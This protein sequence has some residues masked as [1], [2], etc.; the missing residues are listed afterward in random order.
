MATGNKREISEILR[1]HKLSNGSPNYPTLFAIPTAHRITSLAK[2]NF[3]ETSV[4]IAAGITLATESMNLKTPMN[5]AQIV[6]LAEEIIDTASEDNLALEDVML[7][8]QGLVRGRYG[9]LYE[10]MDIPKFME[11][12]E[13]YRQERHEE[14]IRARENRH[15]ELKALGDPNRKQST[16]PISQH[17]S[18]FSGKLAA[19][20]D[21]LKEQRAVNQR[22][23]DEF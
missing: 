8:L 7:F 11:R 3:S 13:V 10:S 20:K 15:L 21:E 19:Y 2:E 18:D 23:R 5:G 6:D 14:L 9:P 22:L 1:E 16:D 4:L 17:L 12:F